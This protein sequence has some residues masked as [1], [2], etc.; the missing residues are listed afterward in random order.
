[1]KD[2]LV[3]IFQIGPLLCALSSNPKTTV[4]ARHHTEDSGN[5]LGFSKPYFPPSSMQIGLEETEWRCVL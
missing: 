1:M 3:H 2:L 4:I 5:I